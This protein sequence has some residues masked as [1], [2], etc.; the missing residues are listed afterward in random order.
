M[1]PRAFFDALQHSKQEGVG[2]F[3]PRTPSHPITVIIQ[4]ALQNSPIIE[5]LKSNSAVVLERIARGAGA[6]YWYYCQNESAV[7][8]LEARLSV[9]SSVDFYFDG[10]ICMGTYS[11]DVKQTLLSFYCEEREPLIGALRKD[12][13]EIHMVRF[14]P[15]DFADYETEFES[16]ALVF[17]GAYPSY[18]G[19]GVVTL[20]LPDADG[21]V[22]SHPY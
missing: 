9:G 5:R 17:Y 22:R 11:P 3:L 13:L 18:E 2:E 12:G 21:V 15:T 6:T 14:D 7:P 20:T 4:R 8:L 10:R 19:D 1:N 16:S